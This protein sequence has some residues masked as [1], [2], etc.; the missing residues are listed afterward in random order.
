MLQ[1]ISLMRIG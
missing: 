1:F